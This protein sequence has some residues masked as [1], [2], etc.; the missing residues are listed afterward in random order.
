[1]DNKRFPTQT[2]NPVER[3]FSWNGAEDKGY[4]SYWDGEQEQK[5]DF[6]F[7]FLPLDMLSCITGYNPRSE[8]SIYSNEVRNTQKE[9]MNVRMGKQTVAQG[10]YQDIKDSVVAK[11]G[12]YTSSVYIAYKDDSGEL[13]V[14][15]I[16]FKGSSLG[17]WIDLQKSGASLSS[18]A[19]IVKG[20]KLDQ[21]G[22]INFNY[23]VFDTKDVSEETN[24]EADKL[25]EKVAS[26]LESRNVVEE[27]EPE[28]DDQIDSSV[29]MNEELDD[30]DDDL[31]F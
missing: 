31:P 5:V 17:P 20:A 12:K 28:P 16:K 6:P 18:Q 4:I 25:Y 13:H 8:E 24:K 22:S 30:I 2:V 21:T 14:G 19:V 26:Y 10:L 29:D 9:I 27:A 15:N 11:G 23:P 1:M 7:V 3:Y